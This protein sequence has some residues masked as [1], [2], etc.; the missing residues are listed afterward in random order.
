MVAADLDQEGAGRCLNREVLW[1][2]QLEQCPKLKVQRQARKA[3]REVGLEG[4]L[5]DDLAR[6]SKSERAS[7]DPNLDRPWADEHHCNVENLR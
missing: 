5:A 6:T 4:R 1:L 3:R 7:W 2:E